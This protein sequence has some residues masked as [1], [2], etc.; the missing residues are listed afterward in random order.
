MDQPVV[1]M[2]GAAAT[3]AAV[4]ATV[5]LAVILVIPNRVKLAFKLVSDI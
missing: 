2:I 4:V 1:V 5:G 3:L